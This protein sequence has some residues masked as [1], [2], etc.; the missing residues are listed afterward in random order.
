MQSQGGVLTKKQIQ[1][2]NGISRLKI[3]IASLVR[4]STWI[5]ELVGLIFRRT[6]IQV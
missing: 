3:E 5:C 6:Q 2:S 1:V 4:E